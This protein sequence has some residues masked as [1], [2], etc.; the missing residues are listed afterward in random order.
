MGNLDNGQLLEAAETAF[1][2]LITNRAEPSPPTERPRQTVRDPCLTYDQPAE[3]SAECDGG[4]RGG[5][6]AR[7]G[8]LRTTALRVIAS[9]RAQSALVFAAG[10]PQ[11]ARPL[12]FAAR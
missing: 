12:G 3:D 8:R 11:T 1:D 7:R 2:A 4:H 9:V 10:P 6:R 5:E